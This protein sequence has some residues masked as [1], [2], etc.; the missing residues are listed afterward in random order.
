MT[1]CFHVN[2]CKV[3][4]HSSKAVDGIIEW[5]CQNYES[6]FEDG[7][8]AMTVSR[9]FVHK[10]LGMKLDYSTRG[11]VKITMIPYFDEI[12]NAFDKHKADNR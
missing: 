2:D 3:S 11:Q 6:I 12:L 4:H 1:I 9:G 5:L 7:S 10:Y 8:G